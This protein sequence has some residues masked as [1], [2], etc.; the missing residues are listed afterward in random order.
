MQG[1]VVLVD[2]AN[3]RGVEG[4]RSLQ[5]GK[6]GGRSLKRGEGG[7]RW[8]EGGGGGL[9]VRVKEFAEGRGEGPGHR[10]GAEFEEGG[11]D[12]A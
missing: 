11:R 4:G 1:V 12:G 10:R 5:R 3:L 7:R 6:G 2:E 8:G 9:Q